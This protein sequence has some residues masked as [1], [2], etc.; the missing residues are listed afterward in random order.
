[1]SSFLNVMRVAATEMGV[2]VPKAERVFSASKTFETSGAASATYEAGHANFALDVIKQVAKDLGIKTAPATDGLAAAKSLVERAPQ[3]ANRQSAGVTRA[4]AEPFHV[5]A[6]HSIEMTPI[7]EIVRGSVKNP[8]AFL[9]AKAAATRSE[10]ALPKAMGAVE[11]GEKAPPLV[12]L[13]RELTRGGKYEGAV[14]SKQNGTTIVSF[15]DGAW[16]GAQAIA[17]DTRIFVE[18]NGNLSEH[19]LNPLQGFEKMGNRFVNG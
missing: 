16:K 11:A 2:A 8:E 18:R 14:V 12:D 10:A 7:G 13:V 17:D 3:I 1:M 6:G 4:F 15:E 9:A 5:S 19:A